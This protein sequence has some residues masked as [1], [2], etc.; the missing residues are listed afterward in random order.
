MSF[1]N[2]NGKVFIFMYFANVIQ[3][4]LELMDDSNDDFLA[5]F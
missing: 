3:N 4:K 1:I 5:L 2:Q